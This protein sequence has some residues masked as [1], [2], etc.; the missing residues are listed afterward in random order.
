MG[1]LAFIG[2]LTCGITLAARLSEK[3]ADSAM[4]GKGSLRPSSVKQTERK[5]QSFHFGLL[6][7]SGPKPLISRDEQVGARKIFSHTLNYFIE[8]IFNI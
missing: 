7:S 1:I 6:A 5:L 4:T 8:K 2:E 3:S